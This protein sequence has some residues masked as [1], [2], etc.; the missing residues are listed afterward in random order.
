MAGLLAGRVALVTGEHI[1]SKISLFDR[2]YLT[3]KIDT[4]FSMFRL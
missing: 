3:N 1:F 4:L 2:N